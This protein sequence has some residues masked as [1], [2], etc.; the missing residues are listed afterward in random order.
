MGPTKIR[1]KLSF[2]P[3]YNKQRIPNRT[4]EIISPIIKSFLLIF[5]NLQNLITLIIESMEIAKIKP[6]YINPGTAK[7]NGNNF[8]IISNKFALIGYIMI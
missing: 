7:Y 6:K 8:I 1:L 2:S 4:D 5:F 3:R